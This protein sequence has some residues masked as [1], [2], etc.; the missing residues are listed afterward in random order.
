[1][2]KLYGY[3]LHGWTSTGKRE[4]SF[5]FSLRNEL[6]I[7]DGLLYRGSRIVIPKAIQSEVI[8]LLHEGHVGI[9]V[10]KSISRQCVWWKSIDGDITN[11]VKSC[12][13]CCQSKTSS[14]SAWTSWPEETAK[15]TRVH[16]DFCG[17]FVDG[18][19]ALVIVDAYSRW[20]EVHL[21][22]ST[23]SSET[24]SRLRRTFAQEGVPAVLVSDNG[25]QFCSD[26][27]R[28]WLRCCG[29]HH[30]LT[31]PYHPKSNGLAERFVRTLKD[32]VRAAGNCSQ[33][34]VDR[35]LL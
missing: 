9:D 20:P 27:F 28:M 32:H 15:W 35:F 4:L 12:I 18:V 11:Y 14:R 5:Y 6:T 7:N 2:R 8:A 13:S 34:V 3:T 23:T 22:R 29:C 33:A 25:P 16:V 19:N 10:M 30:V 24:I 31:P 21:M 17:P 1:M 26:E